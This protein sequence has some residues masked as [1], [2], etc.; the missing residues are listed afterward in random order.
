MIL[1][2]G[3]EEKSVFSFAPISSVF[4]MKLGVKVSNIKVSMCFEAGY[5]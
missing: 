4:E 1:I 2:I 3:M 5:A